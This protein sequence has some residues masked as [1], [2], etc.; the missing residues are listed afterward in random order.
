MEKVVDRHEVPRKK[1]KLLPPG[2]RIKAPK[3]QLNTPIS[4]HFIALPYG[5][6]NYN[7]QGRGTKHTYLVVKMTGKIFK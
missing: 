7:S 6:L 5:Q 1:K 2:M 4:M 3:H